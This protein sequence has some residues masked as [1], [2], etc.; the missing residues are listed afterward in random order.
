[1][2]RAQEPMPLCSPLASHARSYSLMPLWP[3]GH[4]HRLVVCSR[5]TA[6]YRM[7]AASAGPEIAALRLIGVAKHQR[8]NRTSRWDMSDHVAHAAIL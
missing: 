5:A 1:V 6:S 3:I 7:H 2:N 4:S 8:R